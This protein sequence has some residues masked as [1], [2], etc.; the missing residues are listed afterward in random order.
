MDAGP[1]PEAPA[2]LGMSGAEVKRRAGSALAAL[3]IRQVAI[4]TVGLAGTVVLPGDKS[5]SHRYGMIASLA[6]GTSKIHNYSTGA[7]CHSTL[8]CV[9]ALGRTC[10]GIEGMVYRR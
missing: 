10:D 7:D 8:D 2:Q 1:P 4:R 9:R 5:I 3:G 6:Q